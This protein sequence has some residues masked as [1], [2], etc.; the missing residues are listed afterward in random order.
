MTDG[1]HR[2]GKLARSLHLAKATVLIPSSGTRKPFP[3]AFGCAKTEFSPHGLPLGCRYCA[4]DISL[5][6]RDRTSGRRRNCAPCS[7]G[8]GST[9]VERACQTHHNA[10]TVRGSRLH[11]AALLSL[12]EIRSRIPSALAARYPVW[13]PGQ[14]R[15]APYGNGARSSERESRRGPASGRTG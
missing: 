5:R 14:V 1:G 3:V 4:L 6:P 9:Q 2:K 8:D 11:Q 12:P 7:Q 10:D 13:R 15:P